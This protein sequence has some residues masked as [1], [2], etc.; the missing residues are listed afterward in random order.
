WIGLVQLLDKDPAALD[1]SACNRILCG[2]SAVPISL[3]EGLRR[4]GLTILQAWGMTEM[5]PIG[6]MGRLQSTLESLPPEDQTR[7]RAKV[8]VPVPLVD[9][10]VLDAEGKTVPWDGKT[11]GE[12]Q[13]RGP[14]ITTSYYHGGA[15]NSSKFADGWLRTGDVVTIDA[16]GYV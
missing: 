2:G 10:R 5:S 4:H 3:I 7:I 11:F 14:W 12:L 15:D 9:F 16:N 13:V 8:G 6:T 1:L